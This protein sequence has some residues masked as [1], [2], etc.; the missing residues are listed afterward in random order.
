MVMASLILV[1]WEAVEA[2]GFLEDLEAYEGSDAGVG[3]G[4]STSIE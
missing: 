2:P 4:A 1:G 3:K